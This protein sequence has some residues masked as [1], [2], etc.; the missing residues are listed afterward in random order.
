VAPAPNPHHVE[1]GVDLDEVA[2][3]FQFTVPDVRWALAYE[4]VA[5]T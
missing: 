4:A 5:R 2:E 3:T 1:E